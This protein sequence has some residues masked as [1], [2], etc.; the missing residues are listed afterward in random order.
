VPVCANIAR[1]A[2]TTTMALRKFPAYVGLVGLLAG[3]CSTGVATISGVGGHTAAG[4]SGAAAGGHDAAGA[5]AAGSGDRAGAGAGA[6]AGNAGA[7]AQ[8]GAAG[9]QC[10]L[11]H[12]PPGD[13]VN[14][15][16]CRCEP[17]GDRGGA[18][19][20]AGAG[21]GGNSGTGGAAGNSC[22]QECLRAY[23]CAATCSDTPVNNGCCPCPA[24]TI[25]TISCDKTAPGHCSVPCTGAAPD[26]KVVSACQ[27]IKT[28]ADCT[29]YTSTAFPYNCAWLVPPV[30]PC[31]VP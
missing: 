16:T 26:P 24:G 5:V 11:P 17:N 20:L 28:A 14:Q 2:S 15:A 9:A 19:S 8:A 18:G 1:K 12:C 31:L 25:D 27:S 29:A 13:R 21:A 6:A 7:H 30:P 10:E 3:A 4:A 23:T 22:P